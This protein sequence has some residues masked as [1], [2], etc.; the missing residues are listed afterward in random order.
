MSGCGVSHHGLGCYHHLFIGFLPR[1]ARQASTHPCLTPAAPS[2][3][4]LTHPA[5]D[6]WGHAPRR[7]LQ[8]RLSRQQL[9]GSSC[10]TSQ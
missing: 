6:H 2:T 1:E 10:S 8:P 9:K 4:R 7:V 5:P 3:G